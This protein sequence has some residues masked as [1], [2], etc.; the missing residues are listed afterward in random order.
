MTT[1]EPEPLPEFAAGGPVEQRGGDRPVDW[2][3]P[4]WDSEG[5]FLYAEDDAVPPGQDPE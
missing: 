1:P 2:Q 3:F 4:E 5:T